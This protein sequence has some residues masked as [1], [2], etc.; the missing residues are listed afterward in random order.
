VGCLSK[1]DAA[2]YDGRL[3]HCGGANR[4]DK[5]RIL[6]YVTFR[7]AKAIGKDVSGD[8]AAAAASEGSSVRL[9]DLRKELCGTKQHSAPG[10]T[11]GGRGRTPASS[12]K[13]R[14]GRARGPGS[15]TKPVQGR[16]RAASR[17]VSRKSR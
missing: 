6:F 3:L 11:A 12:A 8:G 17:D 2:L 9:G 15:R 7:H 4:S 5:L 10:L 13:G 14:T 1:G 16:G